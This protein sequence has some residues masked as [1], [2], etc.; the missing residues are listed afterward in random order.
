LWQELK[1]HLSHLGRKSKLTETLQ[2]IYGSV[3]INLQTCA[4]HRTGAGVILSECRTRVAK[5]SVH[6]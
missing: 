2:V 6:P 5:H 1:K 4:I 3:Q